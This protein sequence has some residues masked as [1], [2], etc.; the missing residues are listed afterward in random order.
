MATKSNL[1][2]F[3]EVLICTM[4]AAI[5]K[6]H[7]A[8]RW[9]FVTVQI[10]VSII[11]LISPNEYLIL[12]PWQCLYFCPRTYKKKEIKV[13]V[14]FPGCYLATHSSRYSNTLLCKKPSLYKRKLMLLVNLHKKKKTRLFSIMFINLAK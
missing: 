2:I 1:L 10:S 5:C 12:W 3:N 9:K 11:L 7:F 13:T 4:P 14:F 6:L 8:L